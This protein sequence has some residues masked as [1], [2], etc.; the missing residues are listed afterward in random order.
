METETG[1]AIMGVLGV[2]YGLG[3]A[4]APASLREGPHWGRLVQ[5]GA[6]LLLLLLVVLV[7]IPYLRGDS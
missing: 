1:L 2:A 3:V 5:G 7:G 4:F 6:V